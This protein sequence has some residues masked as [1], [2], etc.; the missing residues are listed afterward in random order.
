MRFSFIQLL[1]QL[2]PEKK[3][4][5]PGGNENFL[6][7]QNGSHS[8]SM[9]TIAKTFGVFKST[10]VKQHFTCYVYSASLALAPGWTHQCWNL[11]KNQKC[12]YSQS[13]PKSTKELA[14]FILYFILCALISGCFGTSTIAVNP[15][16]F[17]KKSLYLW[18]T[19]FL[20][21]T[22]GNIQKI[23]TWARPNFISRH[24][25]AAITTR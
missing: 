13:L 2:S 10:C 18:L 8:C 17:R 20:L 21:C 16:H 14:L 15:K 11:V 7:S 24:S 9:G 23:S 1:W 12:G 4:C 25:L 5:T 22:L 3:N 19:L 6:W